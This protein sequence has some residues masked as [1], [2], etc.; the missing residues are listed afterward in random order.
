MNHCKIGNS[1][2]SFRVRLGLDQAKLAERAKMSQS[3][4]SLYEQGKREASL[5][6][7]ERIAHAL[8]VPL[9]L[10]VFVGTEGDHLGEWIEEILHIEIGRLMR[11][12]K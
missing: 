2:H 5:K 10:L 12:A 11:D 3:A 9:V 7:L 8:D 1:I 4:L 6:A